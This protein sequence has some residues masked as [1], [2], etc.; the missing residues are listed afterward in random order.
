MFHLNPNNHRG[1]TVRKSYKVKIIDKV[2]R[3]PKVTLLVVAVVFA[4]LSTSRADDLVMLSGKRFENVRVTEITPAT[5]TFV[6]SSGVARIAFAEF[7]PDVQKK[8]GYDEAKARAWLAEQARQAAE[9]ARAEQAQHQA[10]R[11]KR[12]QALRNM[13]ALEAWRASLGPGELY[14]DPVSKQIRN[15]D[16]DAEMRGELL[17]QALR[18]RYLNGARPVPSSPAP[19]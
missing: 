4:I 3:R 18:Q 9:A 10:E 11:G 7:G 1:K 2:S 15:A 14:Y 17:K 5:I 8:Y 19:H 12:E 6:H 13:E 16:R